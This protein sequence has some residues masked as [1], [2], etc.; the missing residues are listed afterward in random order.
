MTRI[1]FNQV[2]QWLREER[3]FYQSKKFD[4]ETEGEK[5]TD[6]WMQ[7]FNS[8]MQR[9]PQFGTDSPQGIQ[10]V[11][12]LAATAVACAEHYAEKE[13]LPRPG[14]PSGEIR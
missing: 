1:T 6:W 8:Y 4:Y 2:L 3:A 10:A 11:L 14:F 5:G 9:I 13:Y 12:K 7:Q